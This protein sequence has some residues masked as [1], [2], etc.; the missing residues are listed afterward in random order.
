[1]N[2]KFKMDKGGSKILNLVKQMKSSGGELDLKSKNLTDA[3][4]TEDITKADKVKTLDLSNNKLTV[5]P[6][7]IHKLTPVNLRISSNGITSVSSHDILQ[8]TGLREIDMKANRM[9]SFCDEPLTAN[10][11]SLIQNNFNSL[12]HID[13]S[14]NNLTQIAPFIC[15]LK[16]LKTL[17][18]AFNNITSLDPLFQDGNVQHLDVLDMSN[19]SL[20]DVPT[21]I[22]RWQTLTTLVLQNNNIKTF[23][24]EIGYLTNLKNLNILGNPSLLIKNNTASKGVQVILNYLKDRVAD[25]AAIEKD[26][27]NIKT[28]GPP[29]KKAPANLASGSKKKTVI[30]V[31]DDD[32]EEEEVAPVKKAPAKKQAPPP[33]DDDDEDEETPVRKPQPKKKPAPPIEDDEE[34]DE[35][36]VRKPQPKKKAPQPVDEDEEE[37][38]TPVRKPQPKKKP[39]APVED[40]EEEEEATPVRK[41]Q[42]KKKPVPQSDEEEEDEPSPPKKQ[43]AKAPAK[44]APQS[45]DDEEEDQIPVQQAPKAGTGK[46]EKKIYTHANQ[47]SEPGIFGTGGMEFPKKAEK[48]LTNDSQVSDK[49]AAGGKLKVDPKKQNDIFSTGDPTP[50]NTGR[51]HTTQYNAESEE[52]LGHSG[53]KHYAAANAQSEQAAPTTAGQRKNHPS[54]QSDVWDTPVTATSKKSAAQKP[55]EEEDV[56]PATRKAHPSQASDIWNTPAVTKKTPAAA[57]KVEESEEEDEAPA[58]VQQKKNKPVQVEEDEEEEETPKPPKK[59]AKKKAVQ[60]SEDDEEEDTAPPKKKPV[61]KVVEEETP[62]PKKKAPAQKVEVSEEE[63]EEKPAPPAKKKAHP[64]KESEVHDAPARVPRK[65]HPSDSS[66]IWDTPAPKKKAPPKQ[67]EEEDEEAPAPSKKKSAAPAQTQESERPQTS[68]TRQHPSQESEE[69]VS[70]VSARGAGHNQSNFSK[71]DVFG[72]GVTSKGESQATLTAGGLKGA[73]VAKAQEIEAKIKVLQDQLDN[74]YNLS[75][76]RAAEIKKEIGNLRVQK[77]TLGK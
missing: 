52:H 43:P 47:Q 46:P 77:N 14:Q 67:I 70:H 22:Y 7:Y 66:D 18:L 31:Q 72:F 13:L 16:N 42:P 36:P 24:P 33:Q 71:S 76:A 35:T 30:P 53:K 56:K 40:D 73:D 61:Q 3:D 74:D 19:N 75:K 57:K 58:P 27:Q 15:E 44:K 1:L 8:F 2:N 26:L 34:E 6:D 62:K 25:K 65:N 60:Q 59:A 48:T 4:I 10:S 29:Q 32:E 54:Q 37:E 5:F 38:E 68:S 23:A 17:V 12:M 20:T 49:P 11:Y 69:K 21:N 45:E 39:A 28:N 50:Q 41:P 9:K 51:K 55:A 64:S 63:E